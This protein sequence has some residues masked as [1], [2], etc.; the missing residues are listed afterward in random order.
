LRL[1]RLF[2]AK[3]TTISRKK[4]QN[5][6]KIAATLRREVRLFLFRFTQNS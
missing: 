2:A 6:Q 1:L 4:A 5:T 3:K